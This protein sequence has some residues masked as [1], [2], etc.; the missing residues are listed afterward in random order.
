MPTL[1]VSSED[2]YLLF[3]DVLKSGF[4]LEHCDLKLEMQIVS[5]TCIINFFPYIIIQFL[6]ANKRKFTLFYH[7]SRCERLNASAVIIGT[8]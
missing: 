1:L 8:Q 2:L 3:Q 7:G 5:L 4:N 6:H